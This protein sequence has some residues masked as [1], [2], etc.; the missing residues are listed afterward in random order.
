MKTNRYL[1]VGLVASLAIN[2]ALV[3]FLLG[4]SSTMELGMQRVDPMMGMRGL[5]H[6][7][8]EERREALKP[9]FREYFSVLR[10]RFREVRGAQTELRNA[11]LSE[12]LDTEAL[13]RALG[14]FNTHLFESQANGPEALLSLIAALAMAERQQLI[15]HLHK[16]PTHRDRRS[17]LRSDTRR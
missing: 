11:I 6:D 13:R 4:R 9:Y 5:I 7:L 2:L 17:R 8:P 1:I 3:G 12:P 15:R 10:P 14:S 16:P